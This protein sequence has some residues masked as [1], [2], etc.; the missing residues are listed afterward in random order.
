M[1]GYLSANKLIS[2]LNVL[3]ISF[4]G[5][6]LGGFVHALASPVCLSLVNLSGQDLSLKTDIALRTTSKLNKRLQVVRV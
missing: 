6:S 5:T 3:M 1:N 2:L 4:L